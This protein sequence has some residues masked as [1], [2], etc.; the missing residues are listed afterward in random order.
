MELDLS[1]LE[2][3]FLSIMLSY[4]T[5]DLKLKIPIGIQ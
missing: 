4:L 2:A 3:C 1:N 5:S